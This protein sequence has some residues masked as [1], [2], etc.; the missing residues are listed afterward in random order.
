MNNLKT[1]EAGLLALLL[2]AVAVPTWSVDAQELSAGEIMWKVYERPEGA[3]RT[4]TLTMVLRNRFGDERV[5][6]IR[7][8]SIDLGAVEKKLMFFTAPADVK[9]TSF[10]IW[11]YDEEGREDD[12]WIYLPALR[13]IKRISSESKGDYFMGSDFTY[14]DLGDRWPDKDTHTI[15]RDESLDGIPHWVIESR[16]KE[17]DS[18]YSR[19]VVW[20]RQDGSWLGTKKEFYDPEGD[21]LKTL[22]VEKIEE[23]QGYWTVMESVMHNVQNDHRTIMSLADVSIDVGLDG[24]LFTERSMRRGY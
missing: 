1:I 15:L 4:S 7:Q 18:M 2:L 21:L 10:M 3:D 14:D 5:R 19:T 24:E 16:P 11:S 6:S 17:A 8:F 13:K 12:Q 23:I 9:D 22:T 20:V